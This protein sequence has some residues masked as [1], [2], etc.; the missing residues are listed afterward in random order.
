LLHAPQANAAKSLSV[1]TLIFAVISCFG[2]SLWPHFP[3]IGGLLAFIG[4]SC[5]TCCGD[6]RKE[7]SH[8]C[9]ALLCFIAA[10]AHLTGL[11][12]WVY[13]FIIVVNTEKNGQNNNNGG[14]LYY[15]DEGVSNADVTYYTVVV[16]WPV[17][18]RLG[19]PSAPNACLLPPIVPH[20][21]YL[22]CLLHLAPP[23]PDCRLLDLLHSRGLPSHPLQA[24][25][26]RLG[27]PAPEPY[28]HV[29]RRR[30]QRPVQ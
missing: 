23:F 7:Q 30:A 4:C 15:D 11:A 22:I 27:A 10:L 21:P 5:L 9:C 26:D 28:R 13:Y 8:A 24:G 18:R 19:L 25:L 16:L 14:Q 29:V 6:A 1:A 2:F 3:A 17:V 20:S 12:L